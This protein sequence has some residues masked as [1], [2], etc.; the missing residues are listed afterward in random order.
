MLLEIPAKGE[1]NDNIVAFWRPKQTPVAHAEYTF[2]YRLHW[3]A[4]DPFETGLGR[5]IDSRNGAAF[6]GKGMEFVIDYTGG[7][8]KGL[9]ADA[10]PALDVT[11]DHGKLTDVV[12]APNPETGGWRLAFELDPAG[13]KTIELRAV[14]SDAQGP[15]AETWLYRWTA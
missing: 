9:A 11:A 7:R 5:V 6:D 13:A 1:V 8:L 10:K 4:T 12:A 14:M 3:C 15:L 2:T